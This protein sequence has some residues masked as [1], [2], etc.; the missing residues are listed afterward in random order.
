MSQLLLLTTMDDTSW[1]G[2]NLPDALVGRLVHAMDQGNRPEAEA[3]LAACVNQRS[4][5]AQAVLKYAV[6][7]R[8]VDI[9]EALIQHGANVNVPADDQSAFAGETLLMQVAMGDG[10]RAQFGIGPQEGAE[11]DVR[12]ARLLLANGAQVAAERQWTHEC[13]YTEER[14]YCGQTAYD[15]AVERKETKGWCACF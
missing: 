14:Y 5:L 13:Y 11:L 1:P 2:T 3:V 12:M 6:W 9:A 10:S 7:G 15:F 4:E 8:H